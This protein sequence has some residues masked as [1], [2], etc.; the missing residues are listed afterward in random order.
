MDKTPFENLQ[1]II[2][3]V[4]G[5]LK[6]EPWIIKELKTPD[7]QIPRSFTVPMDDKQI[8]E[9]T[10]Y[11]IQYNAKRGVYKGGL[12][13]DPQVDLEEMKALA[14]WMVF[15]TAVVNIDFGGAKG[16]M[17]IDPKDPYIKRNLERIVKEMT[18]AIADIIGP[19]DDVPAPDVGTDS[20]VMA[21]MLDAWQ[22]IHCGHLEPRGWGVVTGKPLELHGCPGRETATA[23][24]GK[25]VLRQAVKDAHQFGLTVNNLAGA[26]VVIQGF[27]NAGYHFA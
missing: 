9:F 14:G 5:I 23:R 22:Q 27:G 8:K 1:D 12:R 24:G 15:K 21:W 25:F 10:V 20:Q 2:D 18:F 17:A 4:G 6:I 13:F 16:G 3:K 7:R 26:R 19:E 11:R